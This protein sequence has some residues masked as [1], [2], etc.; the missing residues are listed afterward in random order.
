[1]AHNSGQQ[2]KVGSRI[3]DLGGVLGVGGFS[4]VRKGTCKN[5]QRKVALKLMFLDQMGSAS[6]IQSQLKQVQK[7][8]KAMKQLSHVNIIRLLGYDL[9]SKLDSRDVIV[10]VQELAPRGELFDYLM[11]T[12]NF[13]QKMAIALFKQ[14]MNGLQACHRKGI[15]HRDLKPENL[16]F[17]AQFNLK[18]ADFGFSYIFQKGEGPKQRMRTELGTRGYMAPEILENVKYDEKTDVFAAGVI[19]FICLAGFPP[20]QN[21]VA[22]DWWFDKLQKHKYRLF[23]MAHERTAS[24][25]P[26]AKELIQKMLEPNPKN[27]YTTAQVL[28][29]PFLN[30]VDCL[31]KNELVAELQRRSET[32][33]TEK[34]AA[35]RPENLTRDAM[36]KNLLKHADAL[37]SEKITLR[38]IVHNDMREGLKNANTDED[39]LK[40]F[41]D[42]SGEGNRRLQALLEKKYWKVGSKQ[43]AETLYRAK[44]VQEIQSVLEIKDLLAKLVL[45]TMSSGKFS[46]SLADYDT[47]TFDI[48]HQLNE[49][50]KLDILD[51]HNYNTTAIRCKFGFDVLIFGLKLFC[52]GTQR[53]INLEKEKEPSACRGTMEIFDKENSVICKFTILQK[54]VLP[55]ENNEGQTVEATLEYALHMKTTLYKDPLSDD[56]VIVFQNIHNKGLTQPNF[57]KIIKELTS[58]TEYVLST[59][60]SKDQSFEK[61]LAEETSFVPE[62]AESTETKAAPIE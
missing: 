6:D 8:I 15:A 9:K 59:G 34:L 39:L 58:G 18:I 38:E 45:E 23:W 36:M 4:E 25:T 60:F 53:R 54:V 32:V 41:K 57:M 10:M 46:G 27:R 29:S 11:Y 61:F 52:D 2:I 31:D 56:N 19:L 3:Y 62:N 30:S 12:R 28:E 13:P 47:N 37:G 42:V 48:L 17:D 20:F 44:T 24:F 50:A 40:V 22:S 35:R 16:L 51:I 7:E 33:Q 21:A 5:T 55:D 1:M 43:L 26:E 49:T 14:L